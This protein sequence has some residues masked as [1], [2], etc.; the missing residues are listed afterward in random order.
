MLV[1][2]IVYKTCRKSDKR[3]ELKSK[4]E[5]SLD[6]AGLLFFSISML[7]HPVLHVA[8]PRLTEVRRPTTAASEATANTEP[9]VVSNDADR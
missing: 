9:A 4:T 5:S 7:V 2:F 3:T 1:L 8:L 6:N